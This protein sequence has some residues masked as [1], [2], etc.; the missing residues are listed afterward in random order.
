MS[1]IRLFA[2]CLLFTGCTV[3]SNWDFGNLPDP[4]EAGWNG[5][6]ICEALE[7]SA[8]L[9]VLRCTFPPGGG[10]ERHYHVA[11]T[12]YILDGGAM[13]I[14]DADGTRTVETRSGGIWRSERI[15]WHEVVNVG[16]T[17]ASYLII[18]SK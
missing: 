6:P 3:T 13:Q 1:R 18:E 17:T 8:E 7:E 9:R 12:G 10:H 11:H 14:T 4:L 5:E 16:D 15:D 2:I